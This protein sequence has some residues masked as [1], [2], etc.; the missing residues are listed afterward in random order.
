MSASVNERIRIDEP[1]LGAVG[2]ERADSGNTANRLAAKLADQWLEDRE[3]PRTEV[4]AWVARSSWFA[5]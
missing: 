4:K 5:V 1:L 2:I 3:R